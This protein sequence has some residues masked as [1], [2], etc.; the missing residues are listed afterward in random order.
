MTKTL[1]NGLVAS[2]RYDSTGAPIGLTYDK[3]NCTQNCRWLEFSATESIHGQ[4]LRHDGTLSSQRYAYDPAGRLT[5]VQ[6][7]PAGQGCTMRSYAFDANS[8][9]RELTTR[10]PAANGSCNPTAAGLNWTYAY[11]AADRLTDEG[12]QYDAFGRTTRLP[13][14]HAG[15][16]ELTTGY[17]TNDLVHTQAQNGT[18]NTYTLDPAR[19]ELTK[20]TVTPN[21]DRTH[22]SHYADASDAPAWTELG[23]GTHERYISGIDGDLAAIQHSSKGPSSNSPTS[24]ATSSPPPTPT[25]PPPPDSS[26]PSTPTST[27]FPASRQTAPTAGSDP[28]NAPPR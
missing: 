18:T 12:T 24:T 21:S 23:N 20:R 9:G 14:K 15:G 8:N 28:S 3:Q 17:Y 2:T 26:R 6:D 22:T 10:Q 1:P 7:R 11:D 25:P 19:R 16:H 5:G 4:W 27:A 13:A